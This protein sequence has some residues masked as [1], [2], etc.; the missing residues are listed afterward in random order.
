MDAIA[1]GHRAYPMTTCDPQALWPNLKITCLDSR[2]SLPGPGATITCVDLV[3][4]PILDTDDI[5]G[6]LNTCAAFVD[7]TGTFPTGNAMK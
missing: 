1:K 5:R 6:I 4:V 2:I 3:D 7:W